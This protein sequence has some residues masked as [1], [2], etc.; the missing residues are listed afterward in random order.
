MPNGQVCPLGTP[1]V[2]Q[3]RF[4]PWK[5]A[6]LE[7]KGHDGGT[8]DNSDDDDFFV[9]RKD[10]KGAGTTSLH[11]ALAKLGEERQRHKRPLRPTDNG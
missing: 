3:T 10:N 11:H 6:S 9:D 1:V 5:V 4:W 2:R 8:C 7:E